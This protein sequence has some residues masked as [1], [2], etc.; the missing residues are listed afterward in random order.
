MTI[1]LFYFG[2]P[3][4]MQAM[5]SR[6]REPIAADRKMESD[7]VQALIQRVQEIKAM[8]IKSMSPTQ[9]KALKSELKSI[10]QDL[11]VVT[12]VYL[13]VG[14]IIIIILLLLLLL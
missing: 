1:G 6:D 7:E 13:S 14:A 5:N 3:T 12:G 4:N 8:D 11:K 2:S 10:K 9:K